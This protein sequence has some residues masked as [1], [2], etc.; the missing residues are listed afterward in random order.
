MFINQRHIFSQFKPWFPLLPRLSFCETKAP[1]IPGTIRG[2]ARAATIACRDVHSDR[3]DMAGHRKSQQKEKSPVAQY[4][5]FIFI[6]GSLWMIRYIL[7]LLI[8]VKN[9]VVRREQRS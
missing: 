2:R 5:S 3:R 4:C 1:G 7:R 6:T 9:P 8:M